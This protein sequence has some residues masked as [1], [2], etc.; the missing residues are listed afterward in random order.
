MADANLTKKALA[1]ALKSL[2]ETTPFDKISVG[3][4]CERCGLNRKSFYYHFRDKYELL[5]WI[6]DIEFLEF[7]VDYSGSGSYDDH[8][9][10]IYRTCRYFY[11]NRSFYSKA[12]KIQGQNSFSEH[13]QEYIRPLLRERLSKTLGKE[14]SS[15]FCVDFFT[16]ACLCSIHRWLLSRNCMTPEAFISELDRLIRSSNSLLYQDLH[17]EHSDS[18]ATS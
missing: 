8:M 2:M 7:A 6:F 14:F 11:E 18:S 4:I 13:F 9:S 3:Q 16:D 15:D 10:F 17:P 12:L 5:N 1:A